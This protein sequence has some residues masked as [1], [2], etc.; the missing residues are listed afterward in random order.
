[1]A[2]EVQCSKTSEQI[3]R[4]SEAVVVFM[5]TVSMAGR[6]SYRTFRCMRPR[7]RGKQAKGRLGDLQDQHGEAITGQ[8]SGG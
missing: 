4:L 8:E 7:R 3:A 2:V 6:A 1:M 5:I